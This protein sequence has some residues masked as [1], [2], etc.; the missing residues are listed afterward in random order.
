[1]E[2]KTISNETLL[3][4]KTLPRIDYLAFQILV[5]N[6]QVKCLIKFRRPRTIFFD[7]DNGCFYYLNPFHKELHRC[8]YF[9]EEGGNE[10]A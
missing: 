8:G 7:E 6:N 4:V 10:N 1:M 3:R 2:Q 5:S 9:I